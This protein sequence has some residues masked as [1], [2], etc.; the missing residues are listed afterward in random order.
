M[1]SLEISDRV[2]EEIE[3]QIEERDS[4]DPTRLLLIL[5]RANYHEL[6]RV[7]NNPVVKLGD[8]IRETGKGLT[9]VM[10]ILFWFVVIVLPGWLWRL[11]AG[12]TGLDTALLGGP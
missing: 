4:D 6:H 1:Q 5:E 11:I 3:R 7:K 8:V 9:L 12:L 2:I 10:L